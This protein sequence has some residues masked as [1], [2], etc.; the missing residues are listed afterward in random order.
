MKAATV[1]ETIFRE[2]FERGVRL[3]ALSLIEDAQKAADNLTSHSGDLRNGTAEGDEALHDFR[4]AVRRLRSWIGAFRPWLSDDVSRKRR[5]NLS[6]V[7]DATRKTRDA[8]V[9]LEWLRK[10][11]PA[12][13][14]RQ[15]VG[16]SWLTEQFEDERSRGC[17]D[18]LAAAADFASL[19]STLT[20][21]LEFYRAPVRETE[22]VDRFGAIF[23]KQLLEQSGKLRKRLAKVHEFTDVSEAHRARIAAKNLRYVAEPVVKL[24]AGGGAM[25]Q[26]LKTLQDSLGELHDVHVF[27]EELAGATEKAAA[28]RARRVS[29]V[30]MTTDIEESEE[31]RVRRARARDPGPGLLGLARRLHDSGM[32]S[33]GE[34]DRDWLNDAGAEFFERAGKL[35][36][37]LRDRATLGTEI[38]VPTVVT[39]GELPNWLKD[40]MDREVEL[41]P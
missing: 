16:Q 12:L 33:F 4:V 41:R 24:V 39:S 28:S 23:A 38:E 7:A 11:R 37:D 8:A 1:E 31:D 6:S 27:A 30:L 19:A 25:V 20:R 14:A 22:A 34:I 21:K 9:H 5:R 2:P 36:A 26:T 40:V 29:E 18:A 3:V 17:D 32:Q 10:E 15:R 13:S 35:A